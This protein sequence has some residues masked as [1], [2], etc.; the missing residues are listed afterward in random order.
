M[1]SEI[2]S[3]IVPEE[4]KPQMMR[5]GDWM[6]LIF[7]AETIPQVGMLKKMAE[8]SGGKLK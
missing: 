8:V 1:T 4:K 7:M 5:G 3:R 6:K 2:R